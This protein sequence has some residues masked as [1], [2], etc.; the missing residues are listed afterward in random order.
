MNFAI[1]EDNASN[2]QELK[3]CL[4]TWEQ[5]HSVDLH[6]F[7]YKNGSELLSDHFQQMNLI[8][9]DIHLPDITGVEIA[10]RLRKEDYFLGI[11][12]FLPLSVNLCLK[13]IM[14]GHWITF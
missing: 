11:S 6:I 7:C 2:C 13:D 3:Q 9:L 5:E 4:K 12:Y 10:H 8:F 1:V 14:C